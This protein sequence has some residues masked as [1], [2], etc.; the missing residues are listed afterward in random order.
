MRR[1]YLE[2]KEKTQTS[3]TEL[4]PSRPPTRSSVGLLLLLL[5]FLLVEE[6][7]PSPPPPPEKRK[8]REKKMNR[9]KISRLTRPISSFWQVKP[10]GGTTTNLTAVGG[11]VLVLDFDG[12]ILFLADSWMLSMMRFLTSQSNQF[13]ASANLNL[14][15]SVCVGGDRP[16]TCDRSGENL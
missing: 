13:S 14:C 7:L 8:T 3:A 5:L 10:V 2:Q 15:V 12:S 1:Q 11:T 9:R 6:D 4:T 16:T